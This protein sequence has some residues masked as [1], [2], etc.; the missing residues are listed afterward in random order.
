MRPTAAADGKN[1]SADRKFGNTAV[2]IFG[3]IKKF[4][5][6][7]T[8]VG[9]FAFIEAHGIHFEF[10]DAKGPGVRGI[11]FFGGR[12]CKDI[13]PVFAEV[14]NGFADRAPEFRRVLPFVKKARLIADQ[15]FGRGGFCNGKQIFALF[16]ILKF[17]IALCFLLCGCSLAAA[18]RPDG[19]LYY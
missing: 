17:N 19:E 13:Q 10:A 2:K 5:E 4:R 16:L 8:A 7:Y 12:A 15:E 9:F 18:L 11:D 6:R 14:V 3:M 1:E